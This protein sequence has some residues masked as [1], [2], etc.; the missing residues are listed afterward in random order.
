MDNRDTY[1]VL[2][3]DPTF[4]FKEKL[5]TLLGEGI[6]LGVLTEK[7]TAYMLPQYPS[8]PIFHRLPKT[9]KGGFPPI[10]HPIISGINSLKIEFMVRSSFAKCGQKNPWILKFLR[11]ST[12]SVGP[13][14]TH[15]SPLVMQGFTPAFPIKWR[16]WQWCIT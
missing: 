7:D 14:I 2:S 11:C 13:Q 12:I 3:S 4:Q 9:H 5:Q 6:A 8:V 16:E 10:L 1:T 15:E